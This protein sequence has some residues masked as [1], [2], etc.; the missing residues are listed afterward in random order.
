MDN[1]LFSVYYTDIIAKSNRIQ[2][3]FSK[4]VENTN[5][6]IVGAKYSGID[7]RKHIITH[8][9]SP[10]NL[11]DSILKLEL[12][13]KVVNSMFNG[14]INGEQ[15][16]KINKNIID[17]PSGIS[18]TRFVG[19][20]VDCYYVEKFTIDTTFD[21]IT[22]DQI[23]TIYDTGMDVV[24]LMHKIGISDFLPVR[25]FDNTTILLYPNSTVSKIL[26]SQ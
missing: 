11:E 19:I 22:N 6:T 12:S 3:L 4:D 18:K 2:M 17:L 16:E 10:S 26:L 24:E 21:N 15:I 25:K 14:S 23:I 1:C 20:I 8:C 9:V 7:T 13:I 5:S